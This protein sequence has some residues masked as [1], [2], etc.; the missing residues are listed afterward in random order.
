MEWARH[1][2]DK[3]H[4]PIKKKTKKTSVLFFFRVC[5]FSLVLDSMHFAKKKIRGYTLICNSTLSL[6]V[7]GKWPQIMASTNLASVNFYCPLDNSFKTQVRLVFTHCKSHW[8]VS[9]RVCRAR[10]TLQ[11]GYFP[12]RRSVCGE[13]TRSSRRPA[14][15]LSVSWVKLAEL[16]PKLPCTH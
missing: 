1:A 16:Q 11:V 9:C 3:H 14:S 2:C 8:M 12:L 6:H 15:R 5:L 7:P 10:L 4:V 13:R